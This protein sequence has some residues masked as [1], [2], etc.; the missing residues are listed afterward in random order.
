MFKSSIGNSPSNS[1]EGKLAE[2]IQ[3]ELSILDGATVTTA[4]LNILDGVT[5]TASELNLVDGLVADGIK[6]TSVKKI[7]AVPFL[8]SDQSTSGA[9]DS[10]V[11]IPDNAIITRCWYDVVTTFTGNGDDSSTIAISTEGANDMV[12]AV[13]IQ[14][15][16][17]FDAGMQEG[18]PQTDDPSTY[19]KM[20]SANNVTVTVAI[21]STDTLLSAGSMVIFIEY[22]QSI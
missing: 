6:G 3:A 12:T 7:V 21:V 4:E 9:W 22:V 16:T 18:I 17:P 20:T 1:T 13:A 15:G 5:S 2:L 8:F 19:V 10:A 11:T 14:T